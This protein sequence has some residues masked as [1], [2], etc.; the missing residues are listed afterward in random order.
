[1]KRRR[2]LAVLALLLLTALLMWTMRV[3]LLQWMVHWLDI[4]VRPTKADYVMLLTGDEQTRPFVA[5]ALLKAG[6]AKQAI[7]TTIAAVSEAGPRLLPP[8]H[9]IVRQVLLKRGI[10]DQNIIVLPD[11]ATTTYG[12]AN[13]LAAFLR[14]RPGARV[15]VV[16]SDYHTRRSRWVF[17][18]TLNDRA[19]NLTFVSA[20]TDE[21]D[22]EHWWQSQAGSAA[23]MAEY[24]K[25]PF[26]V[27]CYGHTGYWLAACGG[28]ALLAYWIRRRKTQE[29]ERP[30]TQP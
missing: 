26:Y 20:P 11:T 28:L 27:V 5:A 17:L 25:L 22:I 14:Y 3:S 16:T 13:A 18:R 9:E 12:E 29:T 21:F 10:A 8:S 19:M 23:I 6:L 4:G 30:S 15:I 24:L 2:W 1:V 7:V